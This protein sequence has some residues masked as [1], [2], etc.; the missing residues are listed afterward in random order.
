MIAFESKIQPLISFAPF[1]I[2]L[3]NYQSL[4]I[5]HSHG[6]VGVNQHKIKVIKRRAYG[7]HDMECFALVI[8]D[9]FA[10]CN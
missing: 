6:E 1:T 8:K 10:H 4:Q 2:F 3:L 7:F 9:A 5:S